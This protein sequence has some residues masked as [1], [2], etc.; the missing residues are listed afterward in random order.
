MLDFDSLK[1]T[2]GNFSKPVSVIKVDGND[3]SKD[4]LGLAISDIQV[5]L[6]SGFEAS[7]ASF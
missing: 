3:I 6:T 7:V 1:K 2:Y 5:E 4:K